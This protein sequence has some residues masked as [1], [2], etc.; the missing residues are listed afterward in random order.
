MHTSADGRGSGSGRRSAGVI[1][2]LLILGVVASLAIVNLAMSRTVERTDTYAG[3][4][5]IQLDLDNSSVDL[6]TTDGMTT[7]NQEVRSGLFG[8]EVE[9]EV[10]D[11]VLVLQLSCPGWGFFPF[12]AGCGGSVEVAVPADVAVSGSTGNGGIT[13]D[14]LAAPVDVSTSN[15][16]IE[17]VGTTS[18]LDVHTSNGRITE[19]ELASPMVATRT[20]NGQVTLSFATTPAQVEVDT[21]NGSIVL[22]VP[23]DGVAFHVDAATSNGQVTTDIPTD[24]GAD[25]VL[26]LHTSN[27]NIDIRPIG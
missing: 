18:S 22:E 23:D 1:I 17:V 12:G 10:R 13:I 11:G 19:T 5:A 14:G 16:A 15:G 6:V 21:S 25:R 3:V 20:S 4:T 24:P 8:G 26:D 9:G 2:G 7:V 27:G